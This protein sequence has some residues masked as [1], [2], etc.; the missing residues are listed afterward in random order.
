MQVKALESDLAAQEREAAEALASKRELEEEYARVVMDNEFL[1]QQ[2]L[3]LDQMLKQTPGADAAE[4][5]LSPGADAEIHLNPGADARA[6]SELILDQDLKIPPLNLD[7][8][9]E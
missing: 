7:L 1:L 8:S 3:E 5:H 4:V 2:N 9:A 6:S